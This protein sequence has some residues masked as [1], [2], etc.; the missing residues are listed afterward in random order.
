MRA[1]ASSPASVRGVVSA[2]AVASGEALTL[3]VD[4]G[5]ATVAL[6]AGG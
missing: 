4:E 3:A 5:T 6:P 1:G 2:V